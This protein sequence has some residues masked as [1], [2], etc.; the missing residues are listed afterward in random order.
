MIEYLYQ[1]G[2]EAC[3]KEPLKVRLDGRITGAIHKVEGGYQYKPKGH[4]TGGLVLSSVKEVQ[5]T[6]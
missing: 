2:V 4:T 6:L 3:S 1:E 5:G